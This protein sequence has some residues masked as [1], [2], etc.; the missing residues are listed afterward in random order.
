MEYKNKDEDT[1]LPIRSETHEQ[2]PSAPPKNISQNEEVRKKSIARILIAGIIAL[3]V[4]LTFSVLGYFGYKKF[5]DQTAFD[6]SVISEQTDNRPDKSVDDHD[7]ENENESL[8]C[9]DLVQI[10][11][12]YADIVNVD[13]K[14]DKETLDQFGVYDD[15]EFSS[16]EMCVAFLGLIATMYSYDLNCWVQDECDPIL[17][18]VVDDYITNPSRDKKVFD[19]AKKLSESYFQRELSGNIV[20]VGSIINDL[21]VD[22]CYLLAPQDGE[23]LCKDDNENKQKWPTLTGRGF[24]WGGCDFEVKR[25]NGKVAF[26]FCARYTNDDKIIRCTH[27]MCVAETSDG[28]IL[29]T[30]MH[31]GSDYDSEMLVTA[32]QFDQMT[33]NDCIADNGRIL[34][35][36]DDGIVCD[37]STDHTPRRWANVSEKGGSWGGCDFEVKREEGNIEDYV[38]CAT[39]PDDRIVKCTRDGCE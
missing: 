39:L 25:E 29:R 14:S 33:V 12:S 11:K 10:A 30:I 28:E 1:I 24:E 6:R 9:D 19:H 37:G 35:P 23:D 31:S 15:T 32:L 22:G 16:D 17:K 36:V 26:Q 38:F 20:E 5:G 2:P 13:N 21:L 7:V 8:P 34:E 18:N 27:E 4:I 3:F